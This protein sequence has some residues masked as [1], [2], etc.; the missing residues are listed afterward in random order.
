MQNQEGHN[1]RSQLRERFPDA[2][3]SIPTGCLSEST[4]QSFA[5]IDILYCIKLSPLYHSIALAGFDGLVGAMACGV[6][7]SDAD[8]EMTSNSSTSVEAMAS[9]LHG[10]LRGRQLGLLPGMLLAGGT[11]VGMGLGVRVGLSIWSLLMRICVPNSPGGP[12][13]WKFGELVLIGVGYLR[14]Q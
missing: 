2:A 6:L 5:V 1:R 9:L 13:V 12:Q 10:C 3:S 14:K 11:G 4:A 8:L 7:A